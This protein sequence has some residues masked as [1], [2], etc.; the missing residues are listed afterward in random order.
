M[1]SAKINSPSLWQDL[2]PK[3]NAYSNKYTRGSA[4]I[5]GGYPITGAARLAALACARTGA[6]ITAISS[7]QIALPIYASSMLSVMVKPYDSDKSFHALI[8]DERISAYLIGPGAGV[9][10]ET[11][12]QSLTILSRNKPC[13]LDAD[14]IKSFTGHLATLRNAIQS[15]CVLTPH[16]G[17]FRHLFE[18][19]EDRKN[20]VL[21]AAQQTGA[22]IL[23]KGSDTLVAH[24]DG[25][26]V[27]NKNAPPTL[28][29]A[30]SGDVLAGIITGLLAQG[31]PAF[32]AA[33]A[34]TWIHAEA[35]RLFG[36]GLIAEDLI[37]M[38]PTVLTGL[39][40][41]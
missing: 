38:L 21:H 18:L 24:P 33:M 41:G 37:E 7:P 19:G 28:A 30:G 13:V 15:P 31:M 36:T 20:A 2:L 3:L 34:A 4:L 32:E 9:T 5:V 1:T 6:G 12:A 39:V 23:L 25:R 16:E 27:I 11:M 10:H 14:A 29:T 17:E 40:E 8:S 35:A 22:I 26:L